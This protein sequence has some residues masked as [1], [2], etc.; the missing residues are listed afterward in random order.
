MSFRF[1][2]HKDGIQAFIPKWISKQAISNGLVEIKVGEGTYACVR[3]LSQEKAYT[4]R[5]LLRGD[6]ASF[7]QMRFLI[8]SMNLRVVDVLNIFEIPYCPITPENM[9]KHLKRFFTGFVSSYNSEDN[10]TLRTKRAMD[11]IPLAI[12]LEKMHVMKS[13]WRIG[14]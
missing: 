8:L 14:N 12:F 7:G 13:N 9:E 10:I 4:M 3:S 5:E 11:I 1:V 6:R 2:Y